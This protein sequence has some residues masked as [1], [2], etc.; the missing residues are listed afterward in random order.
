M[1]II[2]NQLIAHL[3]KQN[4]MTSKGKDP[5]FNQLIIKF[6]QSMSLQYQ[7]VKQ[8]LKYLNYNRD[9]CSTT[10]LDF[11]QEFKDCSILIT[12]RRY[13][14]YNQ[15]HQDVILVSD[16]RAYL[17]EGDSFDPVS[18]VRLASQD[19]IENYFFEISR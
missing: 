15:L 18:C 17:V 12:L 2:A 13:S 9:Q 7:K 6:S 3:T 11:L 8:I 4:K 14:Y 19:E 5:C 10:F 1:I 16:L